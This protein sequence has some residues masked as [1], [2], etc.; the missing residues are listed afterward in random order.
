MSDA[1]LKDSHVAIAMN[2]SSTAYSTPTIAKVN[3]AKSL[4]ARRSLTWTNRWKI[5]SPPL[6]AP[7]KIAIR[8]GPQSQ[9][10]LLYIQSTIIP[11]IR[12]SAKG[13]CYWG[14][15]LDATE[16]GEEQNNLIST[17]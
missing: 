6:A 11:R 15:H 8:I 2:A 5:N 1:R 4:W 16:K 12:A 17:V 9:V 14:A 10:G 13:K 7:M 3:P